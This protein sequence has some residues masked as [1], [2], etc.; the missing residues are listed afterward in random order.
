MKE[1]KGDLI[2]L[3]KSGE[4]D[5]IT[6]GCNCFCRMGRGIAPQIKEAFPS[7]W[8]YDKKTIPG[9]IMKLGTYSYGEEILDNGKLL[10]V[11]NSYTL[12]GN[13]PSQKPLDYEALTLC[14][15]KI[16]HNFKG[17][18]IGIPY[19]IGCGLAGGNKNI[20]LDIIK[21]ELCDLEIT[22]VIK[23]EDLLRLQTYKI[24]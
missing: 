16:N 5:I 2:T 17:K 8:E 6:H 15:R 9:D 3:A 13:D 7:A 1:I 18:S 24:R 4:F 23:N 12:Y 11:I 20:V 10:T 21:K 19:V 14:M 22:M